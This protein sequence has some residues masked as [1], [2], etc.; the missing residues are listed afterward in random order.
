[1]LGCK[2]GIPAVLSRPPALSHCRAAAFSPFLRCKDVSPCHWLP[3]SWGHAS[4]IMQSVMTAKYYHAGHQDAAAAWEAA[5]AADASMKPLRPLPTSCDVL[6]VVH[7]YR[8]V[9]AFAEG[10]QNAHGR[11]GRCGN[12]RRAAQAQGGR[13]EICNC[14]RA[15][16]QA[17][18]LAVRPHRAVD[19]CSLKF[20][21]GAWARAPSM[22]A[23]P[24]LRQRFRRD[25]RGGRFD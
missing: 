9:I 6:E 23:S 19:F 11:G 17:S 3:S 4:T 24:E 21:E 2:S 8:R 14:R 20:A 5:V 1:M 18:L 13:R 15:P 22:V 16:R 25:F 10:P 7:D 12:A